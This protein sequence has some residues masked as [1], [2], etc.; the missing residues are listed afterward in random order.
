M[1]TALYTVLTGLPIDDLYQ[2]GLM[3]GVIPLV[4]AVTMMLHKKGPE[5]NCSRCEAI[6]T[7][8]D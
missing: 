7:I 3:L 4:I 8:A 1:T 6:S 5:A 2:I